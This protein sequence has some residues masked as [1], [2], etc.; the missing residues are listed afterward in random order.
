VDIWTWIVIIVAFVVVA[1]AVVFAGRLVWQR[2]RSAALRRRFGPE[3]ER[4]VASQGRRRG[5]EQLQARVRRH[6]DL[7]LRE[8]A[9]DREHAAVAAIA[10]AQES[11]VDAPLTALRDADRIV[12]DVMRERGYPVEGADA[13]ASAMSVEYPELAARY[14]DAQKAF[15]EGEAAGAPDI[16]KM[17]TAFLTYRELLYVLVGYRDA[18]VADAPEETPDAGRPADTV[19]PRLADHSKKTAA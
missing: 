13:R 12:F 14:R 8:L 2:G 15:T 7:V 3:Y 17:H 16:A 1:G 4:V 10:D 9:P 6:D 19:A 5:E 18:T 11:F